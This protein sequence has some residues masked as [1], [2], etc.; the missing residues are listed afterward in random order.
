ML[1]QRDAARVAFVDPGVAFGVRSL[2]QVSG[3]EGACALEEVGGRN[4]RRDPCAAGEA[5]KFLCVA[6]DDGWVQPE[7][8]AVEADAFGLGRAG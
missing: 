3:V 7:H 6:V 5:Q 1:A 2:E 8:A 4:A